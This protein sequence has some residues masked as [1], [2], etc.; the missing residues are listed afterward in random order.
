MSPHPD[1]PG[2]HVLSVLLG[3]AFAVSVVALVSAGALV[4]IWNSDMQLMQT[5]MSTTKAQCEANND[6][7]AALEAQLGSEE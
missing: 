7:L 5:F 2:V 6:R 3:I 1:A 4:A